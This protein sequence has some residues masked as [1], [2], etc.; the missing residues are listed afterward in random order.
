MRKMLNVNGSTPNYL[1]E[2]PMRDELFSSDQMIQFGKALAARHVISTKPSKDHLLK[3]LA[4]NE[5]VLQEIRKLITDAIKKDYQITPA[6]E[7]LIDNFYLIEEHIRIAKTHFPKHYSE[8]LPQIIIG[9]STGITRSYDIALQ[10]ISHNDGRIDIENLSNFLEAYQTVTNLKLGELWS[11]P[12]ML[13]LA[14]IE[15]IRRVSARFANDRMERDLANYWALKMIE[16]AETAPKEIVIAL[17]DM[18]RSNPPIKSAFVAELIRQ[19]RGK[20]PDLALV[21]NWVEQQLSGSGLT[22]A[23][24]VNAENQKQA[25]DQV[26][27]SNSIGSLRTLASIDWR[28][29]VESHSIVEKILLQDNNGI[30][31][32][33]DFSTRDHYRHV[34]EH[35]A[36]KSAL[37]EEGVAQI[38]IQ[39]MHEDRSTVGSDPRTAHVGYYLIGKGVSDTKKRVKMHMS[40]I[41]KMQ[42]YFKRHALFFYIT[43]ILLISFAIGAAIFLKVFSETS[44]TWVLVLVSILAIISA[45]QLAISVVNFF[46]TLL[47][48]P[49]LLPRMDF[50]DNIPESASTLIV[51]PTLLSNIDDLEYLI[52]SLEV[53]FLANRKNNLYFGLLTDFTDAAQEKSDED[54]LILDAA[55]KGIEALNRKYQRDKNDLFLL[56]HRPRI[57][58]P[59]ENV[60][61]GYERKRGK[62]SDLNLLL[63]ENSSEHFSLIVGDQSIFP[64][65]KYVITLDTDTKLPLNTA[66]KLVASMAHPLNR[67]WYDEKKK[68]VTKGYGILQPRV[69]I[70][71]PDISSSRYR[72][73]HGNEPGIDPYTR[74]SSDVYQDLFGEGS[75]IGKGIYDVDI[76]H[77]VLERKFPENRILSHDLLEGCYI[78]SGLLSDV[79]LFEKYPPTYR[80]DMKVRLRWLRGDW[81]IISWLFPVVPGPQKQRYKNPISG[82]SRWKIFDNIRRSFVPIAHTLFLLLAWFVLPS[83]LFWTIAVS[84]IIVFPIFITTLFDIFRKPKNV[85]LRYHVKNSYQ[86]LQEITVKTLFTLISLPYEAYANL[87]GI[88]RTLWRMLISKKYLLEWEPSANTSKEYQSSLAA[89]YATMWVE[90]FLTV[91]VFTYLCLYAPEKLYITAPILFLWI[92][93][94]LITWI[95]SKP[96]AKPVSTLSD[97]QHIFLQ[98]LARKTWNFF[99]QFVVSTDSW[100]PPDNYQEQPVELIAHRTSPTNIGIALLANLSAYEF[101]YITIGK[102]IERSTNTLKTMKIMERYNGHFY[103]WYDTQTLHPLYPKYISTVDSGNLAGHLLVLKQGLFA[104]PHQPI[105]RLKLFEGIRD[106]LGVLLDTL[107]ET[108]QQIPESLMNDLNAICETEISSILEIKKQYEDLDIQIRNFLNEL[109][110]ETNT[111][112]IRWKQMLIEDLDEIH[113]HF[114]FFKPWILLQNGPAEFKN[115]STPEISFTWHTLLR[116]T[117]ELQTNVNGKQNS[118]NTTIEK[119]WFEIMH[120]ALAQ[121]IN[122]IGE[123]IIT[124]KNFA[125]QCDEFADMQWDFLYDKNS[126]LFTIGYNVHDHRIDPSYYDLLASE[127]RLCIFVCIAQGKLPEES[128]FALGRLL[129]NLEGES[130]LLSWSGSMFEY[131]M[132]LLVMPTFENTLLDETYKAAVDWQIKYGKKTGRPWGISES[133]YNMINASSNYQYRAFGAPGLGLKRGL[134]EDTVIAPYATV[135]ALMVEP[136]KACEN[137]ELLHKKGIE[138]RYGFYEAVDYTPS[139]LPRGQ[140]RAIVYSFMTHHHG[141]SLLSLAYLLLDKPMQKLFEAEPQF[142]AT[143]LLLQ[144]RV[145]K[146]TAA[147]AHTTSLEDINYKATAQETRI[148]QTAFTP[149]PE[150]QL[151]SN[152]KYHLMISN[153]GGGYSRWKDIAITRWHDDVTCDNWGSFCYIRD[154]KED[155]IWSNTLQPTL[156]KTLKYEVAYSQGRVDFHISQHEID[157]HTEIVVSPEDDIEMRRLHLTHCGDKPKTIELTS[158][159]EVVLAPAISDLMSPAFS[160]LFVQTEILPNQNAIICT[161]RP[162]SADEHAPW[163]FHL[164]VAEGREPEEISYETDRMAFIGHGN[165]IVKPQAMKPGKLGG[166]QGSVLDPIVA[167]RYRI[168]IQ[169]EETITID[170]VTGIAET[171]EGCQN[172]INKYY[173]NKSHKDRVFELAW[174]HSQVVLHHLNASEREAQLFSR[175]AS[176][177]LYP[178]S[179]FRADP[180]VLINNR[181]QQSGLW[182]YAISGD[183]PIVLLIVES[184]ENIAL[185]HDMIQAHAYWRLKGLVVD[186]VIWNE[187]HY[188]YR[189]SFQSD[190]EALIPPELLGKKGGVFIMASD[191][192]PNEDRILFQTVARIIISD[193]V[194]SLADHVNKKEIAKVLVP[195]IAQSE[196]YPRSEA[197]LPLPKDLLFFNGKGG[198]SADG[199]EYVIISDNENRTPVPWVNVIAN[200]NFGTVISESG[201]T[202]TWTENAHELRLSTWSNDPVSDTSGEAFYIRDE[203]GGH[204]WSTSLLPAGGASP[205][206]TRHGFGYSVFEHLEDGIH[207]EMT[208]FVDI[209]SAVKFNVIKIRNKS[210]RPR[211]LSATGYIEWVLGDVRTKTA[212]HIHTEIDPDSKALFAKN[213]YNTEF[214]CRVAFFDVDY[215]KKSYTGDRTEFLGRNGN[216]KKPDA[217]TRMKLSGKVGLALDPCGAIQVPLFLADGEE[218]EVIFRIGA[219]KDETDAIALSKTFRGKEKAIDALQ[220]VKAY[221]AKTINAFQVETPDT[222]IN[223]IT[224]GWLTYQTLSSRLWGRSGF[225]QSGGAFGFRDQLQ[226]VMSLLHTRP[227]LARKQILLSASRQFKEGDVQHWWHPPVGR[228]VR[229]RISDDYLWLPFVT[230]YYLKH[231]DD[232]S[233]LDVSIDFLDGR[234]LNPG[235]ES[236]YDLPLLAHAPAS[237]YNHC[238]RAI[239][240]GL[241]FGEHGLP[242]IGTG[243][244]NDGF[245]KVGK[246][247]KGESVWLA[248][249]LYEILDEFAQTASLHNDESFAETCKVEATKL[250]ANIDKSAWDGE[251]YKRA[252]FD[253]GTPLG[254]KTDEECMIDSISQSWSVLSGGGNEKLIE[255]AMNSAYKNLVEQEVG[256]IKL[257]T[258]AFDKSELDPGYIKGYVPGVRENGGQY[259]HAAIWMIMAFAKLGNNARVWELLNMIN[260]VNHGKNAE[261]V[262]VYKVEPYVLAADVYSRDPHA[263]RG[264]WTWYTGSAAWLYRLITESFLGIHKE[265]NTLKIIPCI[266]EEWNSYKVNYRYYDKHYHIEII[267]ADGKIKVI[268][269]GVELKG[270]VIELEGNGEVEPLDISSESVE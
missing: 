227:E 65:I 234:L 174:S 220:K 135:M 63:R 58:N 3:R 89:A 39:L 24:M 108:K 153:A 125:D 11:I 88:L 199:K 35:I 1:T 239:K 45:S 181:R 138:G 224:N 161:R 32:N 155:T 137:L 10:V 83:V 160:K 29:F 265:G 190:I 75:F 250:K 192:I 262:A 26:S 221:W 55:K 232:T 143:L 113:Q 85:L 77:K 144:E 247:G 123:L 128:W 20:G 119:E 93:A 129:T 176:S 2:E 141:M 241:N 97:D 191:Q 179:L 71:L 27:I 54:E 7:W 41:D 74:A 152:G 52:E 214:N 270:N 228:G 46:T 169:P 68:R 109:T 18:A 117:I 178:N 207:T 120:F 87:R 204:V 249:F 165:T 267:K 51:V 219:G 240:H 183:L 100:L 92:A 258:P 94:P 246:E 230:N 118:Y 133:G 90:P 208:V 237:L 146:A 177:I 59:N 6:G 259:T 114:L 245:D 255:T 171:K 33:M 53:R 49:N 30:Y 254:S 48:K 111:E 242:L 112:T 229:T 57:W 263:G 194:G 56:F 99:E 60:W 218:Q 235:E 261:D 215:L 25:A 197:T 84:L 184:Q 268:V 121:S 149:I 140:S 142:K 86:N 166:G 201:S 37:S 126:H 223:L 42:N 66:W 252:W 14:L 233:I 209:E 251:W 175:L 243:D 81:Q 139:R 216:L 70:S 185:V 5:I 206:I 22:G 187:T 4:N 64:K 210:G 36:K 150:I 156:K 257:L 269:D 264:G 238:V 180:T 105:F 98:K 16:T 253:D 248:F 134:E 34:V 217:L 147:F 159:A 9:K 196:S 132:P 244:W 266:P 76:F 17:A 116:K 127:V 12:I 260:P 40:G 170:M 102:F 91:A 61:M 151:L 130:I 211:N 106:T 225:Y 62:L 131:L 212:M 158:Y 202:Y 67:A 167:I 154:V 21:L 222:A 162:R 189:Q 200:P 168:T 164:M 231:T 195:R 136:K 44:D 115:I 236:Y 103:N 107:T 43:S 173:D 72:K 145:P 104:I 193:S 82:L 50:S 188:G 8:D 213:Q 172:L 19:L 101:G 205:Y 226:D 79:Q 38:A 96:K 122:A 148:L 186:L 15:N 256:I 13:R 198:F 110:E 73:M 163:M 31:G 95:T 203:E 23:E 182:G 80:A 47:V 69:T 124:S 78:R 157:V 28:N